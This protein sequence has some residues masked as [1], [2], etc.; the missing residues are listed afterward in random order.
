[1]KLF[2]FPSTCALGIHVILEEIG[3]PFEL[4]SV[5]FRN[6]AQHKPPYTALNPKAKVPSLLR[7]DNTLL[8]EYP[9]IAW[10]LARM[11]PEA[12]L[13]PAGIEGEA[14]LLELLDYMIA[15]VHMR[16]FTRM[17]RAGAFTPTVAD[18]PAVKQTGRDVVSEGFRILSQTLGE[19][20]W[21][22]EHY[23]LADP[24]IFFLEYW[25][26]NR[27]KVPMPDN[28]QAHYERMRAR[29]AVMRA[30]AAEGLA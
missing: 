29:P 2:Y 5:D 23:S 14:R 27:G 20:P 16:G 7:D 28:I 26:A 15:T 21:L 6:N 17:F 19:K 12:G 9:A 3:A 25:A 1:M 11:N 30:L 10:Y 24:T 4:E 22:M 8:T 18:E 13:L